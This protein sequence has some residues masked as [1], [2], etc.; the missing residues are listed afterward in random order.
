MISTIGR[1]TPTPCCVATNLVSRTGCPSL[2]IS[3]LAAAT[4]DNRDGHRP[5]PKGRR[6][7]NRLQWRVPCEVRSCE[8]APG[9][10]AGEIPARS[11]SFANYPVGAVSTYKP[12][13]YLW[14]TAGARF[15]GR[16]IGTALHPCQTSRVRPDFILPTQHSGKARV[17]ADKRAVERC[18]RKKIPAPHFRRP[19]C[20]EKPRSAFL[21]PLHIPASHFQNATRCNPKRL[22]HPHTPPAGDFLFQ[23]KGAITDANEIQ[24]H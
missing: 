2:P 3:I 9:P 5:V 4:R 22:S 16:G 18:A 12:S 8:S 23:T 17:V 15:S 6:G 1:R 7:E 19:V 21:F 14:R 11:H 24:T 13:A 10:M 20:R